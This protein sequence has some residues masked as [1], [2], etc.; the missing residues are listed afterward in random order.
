MGF[1][2]HTAKRHYLS[3]CDW[4][5]KSSH[6]IA[7]LHRYTAKIVAEKFIEGIIKLHSMPKSIISDRDPIFIS[8]FWREFFKMSGT[9][10]KLSSVYHPH[11]DGQ[12]EVVNHYVEKYLQWFV[13]Q[14]P[15]KWY[16]SLP[17]TEYWYNTTFHSSISMTPF[18]ALYGH[19]PPSVLHLP[20]QHF[21]SS[22]GWLGTCTLWWAIAPVKNK[23]EKSY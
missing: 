18:Q 4:L 20:W 15:R 10:L 11:T 8:K 1:T 3:C 6:F 22:W 19:L 21:I 9:K 16:S 12:T 7:L 17:W 14:W 5:T 13:H 23:F 2:H